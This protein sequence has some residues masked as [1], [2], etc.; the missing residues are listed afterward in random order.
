MRS[1]QGNWEK[2]GEEEAEG[3]PYQSL[4]LPEEFV[5]IWVLI[6]SPK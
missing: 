3:R 6:S 5:V 1:N 4:Q 2:S